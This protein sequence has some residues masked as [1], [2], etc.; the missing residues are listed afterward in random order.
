MQSGWKIQQCK[1]YF[2]IR[3]PF[4]KKLTENILDYY[5]SKLPCNLNV[6]QMKVSHLNFTA[7]PLPEPLSQNTAQTPLRLKSCSCWC[8]PVEGSMPAWSCQ[9]NWTSAQL[10][11]LPL[12]ANVNRQTNRQ[13]GGLSP[14]IICL[15]PLQ[16]HICK[17]TFTHCPI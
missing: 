2:E 10:Q 15:L 1:I 5:F 7:T 14:H 3:T 11:Q 13:A 17:Y 12:S 8:W 6:K 9:R 16:H 4:I